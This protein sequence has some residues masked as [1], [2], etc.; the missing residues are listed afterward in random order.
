MFTVKTFRKDKE[1]KADFYVQSKGQNAGQPLRDPIA[2]CF[3]ITVTDT[4]RLLPDYLY[5][6]VLA[7]FNAGAFKPYIR[8]TAV[9]FLTIEDFK[10]ALIDFYS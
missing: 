1:S 9:P 10:K 3:E 7:A 8:G 4:E 5:Y 6:M 2:N